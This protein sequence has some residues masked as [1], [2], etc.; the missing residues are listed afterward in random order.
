MLAPSYDHATSLGFNLTDGRRTQTLEAGGVA[1]WVHKGLAGRL[2]ASPRGTR[3]TLVEAALD[4]LSR[5]ADPVS[6]YWIG[7]VDALSDAQ[8]RQ[9]VDLVPELSDP[10]RTFAVAVIAANLRRVLDGY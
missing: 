5:V 2:E 4:A 1:A 9:V 6:D 3:P 8:V 7:Q 10:E